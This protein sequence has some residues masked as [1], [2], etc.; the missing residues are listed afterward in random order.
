[1]VAIFQTTFQ[2]VFLNANICIVI[3]ISL[4]FVHKGAINNIPALV[5]IMDWRQAGDRPL[6]E[7]VMVCFTDANTCIRLSASMS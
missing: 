7:P 5:Q 6:S 2:N 1:M 3:A 4:T